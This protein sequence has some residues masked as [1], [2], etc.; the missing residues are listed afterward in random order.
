MSTDTLTTELR[1]LQTSEAPAARPPWAALRLGVVWLYW[2]FAAAYCAIAAWQM[3][4]INVRTTSVEWAVQQSYWGA[5][6]WLTYAQWVRLL[7]T[8]ELLI[9]VVMLGTALLIVWLRPRDWVAVNISATLL[10]LAIVMGVHGNQDSLIWPAWLRPWRGQI[11]SLTIAGFASG[12]FTLLLLFPNGRLAP[13]WAGR[14][15]AATALLL[16]GLTLLGLFTPLWGLS[17]TSAVLLLYTAALAVWLMRAPGRRPFDWF[18]RLLSTLLFLLVAAMVLGLVGPIPQTDMWSIVMT[19]LL[20]GLLAGLISQWQRYRRYSTPRERQQTRWVVIGVTIALGALLLSIPIMLLVDMNRLPPLVHT[21]YTLLQSLAV[22]AL[23]L[24]LALGL[25]RDG[26]WDTEV[27]IGRALVYVLLTGVVLAAY[28]LTVGGVSLL[29]GRQLSVWVAIAATGLAALLV[30]PL[31]VRLQAGVNRLIYGERDDPVTVL[32]RLGRRLEATQEPDAA[33]A[34]LVE[35]VGY[36]L[37]LPYV[38]IEAPEPGET[39]L[40]VYGAPLGVVERFPLIDQG[41][42]LGTLVVSPRSERERLSPAD[43]RLLENV[44]L[45]AGPAVH[46]QQLTHQL[47]LSRQA[48]V[49]AREEERRRLRRD[50]HDGLGPLLASQALT[51]EAAARRLERDPASAAALLKDMK[52]QTQEAVSDIRR[53]VYDLRPPALDD[54]GLL[55]AL[56]AVAQQAAASGPTVHVEAVEPLPALPAAVEVAAYRIAQEA[57]ANAVRHAQA[58]QITLRLWVA[59]DALHLSVAD[60]GAGLGDE[61]PL[62]AGSGV[63]MRSMAERAAELGGTFALEA[64]ADGVTVHATLPLG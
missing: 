62:H 25:L 37:K 58:T 39:P 23:P 31:R 44:A 38:A 53:I 46:A 4:P 26:L 55:E 32:Q 64:S 10:L 17:I 51:L 14:L 1:S 40:A 29:L 5:A 30:H 24:S 13:G 54:L 41:E 6:G 11:L 28:V 7:V 50:L 19:L 59:A 43:R 8:I 27:A 60:N 49:L 3:I 20:V 21:A 63:G 15:G 34:S 22:L 56:R 33:L 52:K 16:I 57:I 47:K 2:A 18:R 35:T 36:S 61:A 9:A 45:Q 48:I 12:I 42:R